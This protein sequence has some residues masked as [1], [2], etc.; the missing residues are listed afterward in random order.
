[1][2]I[3][4]NLGANCSVSYGFNLPMV[5]PLHHFGF[6]DMLKRDIHL[7]PYLLPHPTFQYVSVHQSTHPIHQTTIQEILWINRGT[8][9]Q[10]PCVHHQTMGVPY[11]STAVAAWT[12]EDLD[13]L[14]GVGFFWAYG[15]ARDGTTSNCFFGDLY[16]GYSL[17]GNI[18]SLF[19][20]CSEVRWNSA[21]GSS[22][23]AILYSTA[24][25]IRIVVW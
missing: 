1:M 22:G 13:H 6:F 11:T 2:I 16:K 17:Y 15:Y 18:L 20:P 5:H 25:S 4:R 7:K 23:K 24:V 19:S 21:S 10:I 12:K 9:H 8:V 3:P 14:L